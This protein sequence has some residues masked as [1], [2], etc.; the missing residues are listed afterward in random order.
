M[1][2]FILQLFLVASLASIVYIMARA[3][4]RAA[5]QIGSPV[6][7][8]D[9]MERWLD[10]LPIHQFDRRINASLF[11]FLRKVRIVVMKLDNKIV[12]GLGRLR[13]NGEN[14]SNGV[15]ELLKDSDKL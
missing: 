15:S 4:P 8:Y 5:H 6:T 11:K 9:Y 13:K 7:F 2:D 3:L 14:D 10:R 1:Y 12:Y